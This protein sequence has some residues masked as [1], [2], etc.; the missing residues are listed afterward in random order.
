MIITAEKIGEKRVVLRIL[1]YIFLGQMRWWI[2]EENVFSVKRWR[3]VTRYHQ[4]DNYG[5]RSTTFC[6]ARNMIHRKH[7]PFFVFC[8]F[9]LIYLILFRLVHLSKHYSRHS[10][11]TTEPFNYKLAFA[12]SIFRTKDT[13]R[14]E[15]CSRVKNN[16]NLTSDVRWGIFYLF[17]S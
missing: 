13:S 4:I 11:V 17:S 6:D 9:M 10:Y 15:F 12:G 14:C 16:Y 3:R 1:K 7:C 5:T 2:T 8:C